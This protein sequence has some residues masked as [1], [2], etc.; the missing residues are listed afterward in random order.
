MKRAA[1]LVAFLSV[2]SHKLS[3]FVRLPNTHL[4]KLNGTQLTPITPY[5]FGRIDAL[6]YLSFMGKAALFVLAYAL[7][8]VFARNSPATF[9]DTSHR[10]V[11]A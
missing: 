5:I 10:A 2:C 7:L 4:V 6:V 1:D 3:I 8:V 9:L 11:L